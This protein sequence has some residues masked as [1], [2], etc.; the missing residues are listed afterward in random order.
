[1][2]FPFLG[3]WE[4][5][6]LGPTFSATIKFLSL[7]GQASS[8][9][10]SPGIFL[11]RGGMEKLRSGRGVGLPLPENSYTPLKAQGGPCSRKFSYPPSAEPQI[12]P[13]ENSTEWMDGEGD[14]QLAVF[15]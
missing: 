2:R 14:C 1:M 12:P 10:I 8:L 7:S 11:E 5:E 6:G 3:L 15:V 13:L 4:Q 9:N